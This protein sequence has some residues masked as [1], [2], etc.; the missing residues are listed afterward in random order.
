MYFHVQC[1]L[2]QI[3]WGVLECTLP[4]SPPFI[5]IRDKGLCTH[6]P[7]KNWVGLT[8]GEGVRKAIT[9]RAP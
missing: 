6:N 8:G 9:P 4:Q 7:G 1:S 5:E 2:G 3:L